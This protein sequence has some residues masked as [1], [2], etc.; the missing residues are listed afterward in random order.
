SRALVTGLK[1]GSGA[2]AN[3]VDGGLTSI[4]SPAITLPATIGRLTFRY[5]LAHSSG[6]SSADVFRAVVMADDGD[7]I[8]F[9]EHGAANDD[10]A[11]WSQASVDIGAY[12]GQTIHLRFEA[13][14]YAGANLLEAA[15]DD[16]RIRRP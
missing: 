12:A 14:D 6:S 10:D 8:V 2:G 7:H 15:V 16:I 5:Y 11:A 13:A 3:D 9:T 4:T 1:A